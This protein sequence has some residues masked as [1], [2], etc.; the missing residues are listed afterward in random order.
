MDDPEF[1][2]ISQDANPD[3][4]ATNALVWGLLEHL[5]EQG[6]LPL[7][8]DKDATTNKVRACLAAN[9]L[10]AVRRMQKS[11]RK[12]FIFRGNRNHWHNRTQIGTKPIMAFRKA[13]IQSGAII[14]VRGH[15][16][17]TDGYGFDGK[18]ELFVISDSIWS[19][20]AST[21]LSF[22]NCSYLNRVIS[23][24]RRNNGR[25]T[26]TTA[27]D[28]T[29][30]VYQQFIELRDWHLA[31]PLI[32]P[33][34]AELGYGSRSFNADSL[35]VGGRYQCAYTNEP[36]EE[37]AKYTLNG[38]PIVEV[39]ISAC[40]PTILAAMTGRVH[41]SWLGCEVLNPYETLLTDEFTKAQIKDIIVRLIGAGNA[42]KR[43]GAADYELGL[44]EPTATNAKGEPTH[45][46]A[47]QKYKDILEHL[48]EMLPCLNDLKRGVLDSNI[49]SFHESEIMTRFAHARMFMGHPTY[50]LHDGVIVPASEAQVA[51]EQ[52]RMN[53][54]GYCI[55]M[56]W[57]LRIRP[58]VT[59]E[60]DKTEVAQRLPMVVS[61]SP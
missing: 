11:G 13:L 20:V 14:K 53:F 40:N 23:T 45:F 6:G 10:S 31:M 51:A 7:G 61:E 34:G 3:H 37:R 33:E 32:T 49:L 35:D 47:T 28:E 57:P 12:N 9:F 36:A 15:Y 26:A 38:E 18:A 42:K 24:V 27:I 29:S 30:P 59:Q 25:D 1:F 56:G 55:Q 2:F 5:H 48:R 58:S 43:A 16:N 39:D 46:K 52:L 50:I 17:D 4:V 22:T 8:K 54:E 60:R 21:E 44:A 19:K 41:P